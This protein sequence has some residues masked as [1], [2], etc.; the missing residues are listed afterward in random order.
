MVPFEK[1]FFTSDLHINHHWINQ[2]GEPRGVILFERTQFK[3]IQ[4]HDTYIHNMLIS[5]AQKH[6]DCGLWILG[7]FGDT[8]YLYW[9]DEMRAYGCEVYFLYGLWILGDFGDT[10]YLYWIDEMRAYGCE[11]YFLYGN[12]DS[13]SDFDKFKEHFNEVY[14]YPTYITKR[15]LL[16]HEPQYPMVTGG[17]NVHG[18]LHGTKLDSVQHLTVSCND[19]NYNPISINP[20][21]KRLAQIP[22]AS[23]KFLEEPFADK[24][25]FFK[26]RPDIVMDK[27]GK[28]DLKASR[29]KFFS[30]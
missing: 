10:D 12:H 14:R 5:W 6:P 16:S 7:D 15:V 8:D 3:T 1:M 9:I 30:Q 4:E 23:F 27:D 22:K 17:L 21:V 11:V 26:P 20:I 19:I 18:H 24:Y 13:A 29:K 25:I 2:S 28:I